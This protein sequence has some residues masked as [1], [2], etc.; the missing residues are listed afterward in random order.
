MFLKYLLTRK[1]KYWN[2]I[3]Y[4][5][6]VNTVET[7]TITIL[8]LHTFGT[9]FSCLNRFWFLPNIKNIYFINLYYFLKCKRWSIVWIQ[10]Y[11]DNTTHVS[12]LVKNFTTPDF[13]RSWRELLYNTTSSAYVVTNGC[14]MCKNRTT[15]YILKSRKSKKLLNVFCLFTPC[16]TSDWLQTMTFHL[17]Y[18][19]SDSYSSQRYI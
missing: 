8:M 14:V 12:N 18:L 6:F 16:A 2:I 15:T 4:L 19:I 9:V 13:H 7:Q 1:H 17:M 5:K 10:L 11:R 3:S